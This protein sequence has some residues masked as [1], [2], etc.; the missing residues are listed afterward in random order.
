MS[1]ILLYEE[2][3]THNLFEIFKYV[4]K[5]NLKNNQHDSK[6][7]LQHENIKCIE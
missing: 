3:Q 6:I 4:Y 1:T 5:I 2:L 7:E